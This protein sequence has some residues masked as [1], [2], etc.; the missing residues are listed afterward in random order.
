MLDLLNIGNLL[1][2]GLSVLTLDVRTV[3]T[4]GS[5]FKR[6]AVA[7]PIVMEIPKLFGE[8]CKLTGVVTTYEQDYEIV[9]R[10]GEHESV[11]P[12]KPGVVAGKLI[13]LNK[14]A[15]PGEPV[16]DLLMYG[17]Q[18]PQRMDHETW[19]I[20]RSGVTVTNMVSLRHDLQP[21][22]IP[23]IFKKLEAAQ[24]NND[25][26]AT[27]FMEA[28]KVQRAIVAEILAGKLP[29][30]A[31]QAVKEKFAEPAAASQEV[32]ASPEQ[33]GTEPTNQ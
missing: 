19:Y 31:A 32:A 8:S 23:Q 24:A 17:T 4:P 27:E 28:T 3:D 33:Q 26:V 7:T 29:D 2:L 12:A 16:Q 15:C 11:L 21:G 25:P 10:H 6:D 20:W 14:K 1:V 5:A 22:W 18:A 30:Q 9:T 13:L